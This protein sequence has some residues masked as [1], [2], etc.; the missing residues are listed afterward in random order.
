VDGP[1]VVEDPAEAMIPLRLRCWFSARLW[2]IH[3]YP[4]RKGGDGFPSHFYTYT[5]HRCGR[6]FGI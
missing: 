1:A 2:D 3:D 5:C 4:V 6:R